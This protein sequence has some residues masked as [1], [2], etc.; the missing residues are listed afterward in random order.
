MEWKHGNVRYPVEYFSKR[1]NNTESRYSATECE[2]LGCILA[3]EHWH[4][5]LVGRAFDILS[6][7]GH[8]LVY[9]DSVEVFKMPSPLVGDFSR[10]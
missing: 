6:D 4:P 7:H 8:H 2:M 1:L 9:Q 3:M 5:Y 10:L